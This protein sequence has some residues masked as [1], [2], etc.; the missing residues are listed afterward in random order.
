LNNIIFYLELIKKNRMICSEMGLQIYKSQSYLQA[1]CQSPTS[2]LIIQSFSKELANAARTLPIGI[3]V[4]PQKQ[5]K[6]VILR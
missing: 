4:I 2:Q 6:F 3:L 5:N 1:H